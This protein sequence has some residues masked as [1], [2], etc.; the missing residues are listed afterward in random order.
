MMNMNIFIS[1]YSYKDVEVICEQYE[2][3]ALKGLDSV[4]LRL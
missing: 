2:E 1:E 4:V 3:A